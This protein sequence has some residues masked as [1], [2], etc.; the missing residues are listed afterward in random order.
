MSFISYIFKVEDNMLTKCNKN[1][2]KQNTYISAKVKRNNVFL[3]LEYSL[4]M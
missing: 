3:C 2:K 4:I 1:D